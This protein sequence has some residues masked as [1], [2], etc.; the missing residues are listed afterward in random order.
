MAVLT[1]AAPQFLIG[2]SLNMCIL[3][4]NFKEWKKGARLQQYNQ[5][6]I[7]MA[8]V[9]ILLQCVLTLSLYIVWSPV[10]YDQGWVALFS[11]L[12]LSLIYFSVWLNTW[13]CVHYSTSIATFSHC[14]ITWMKSHFSTLLPKLI[15]A[16]AVGSF[17]ISLPAIWNVYSET[18]EA[19]RNFSI[20]S[21]VTGEI[22]VNPSYRLAGT[23]LG[24]FL[25]VTLC[26]LCIAHTLTSLLRHVWRVKHNDSGFSRPSL[27]AH[28]RAVRTMV[29]L[30]MLYMSFFVAQALSFVTNHTTEDPL[31]FLNWFLLLSFPAAGSLVIIQAN[32]KLRKVFQSKCWKGLDLA[33]GC[34]R[35]N[36]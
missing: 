31:A 2:L 32:S 24:C 28:V 17:V 6:H 19:N 7:T 3:V 8:T 4:V 10:L 20:N 35:L 30:L 5:L 23:S 9:N 13:L 29:L 36:T 18:Q 25:P 27:R 34:F 1:F 12:P 33:K 21:T 16:S 22:F 15:L 26:S 14:A 11:T